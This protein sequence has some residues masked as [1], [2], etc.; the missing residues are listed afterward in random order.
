MKQYVT[1]E[2]RY[3]QGNDLVK[4]GHSENGIQRYRCNG[5]K[6]S[7]QLDYRYNAWKEG[8]KAQIESQTLNSSGVRAIARNLKISKDTVLS[9]LKKKSTKH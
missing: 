4:N 2:C 9:Y 1:V 7:F 8:I 6:K 3:C 5:C